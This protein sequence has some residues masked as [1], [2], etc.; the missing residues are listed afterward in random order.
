LVLHGTA[1]KTIPVRW[2]QDLAHRIPQATLRLARGGG[3]N[4]HLSRPAWFNQQLR[5]WLEH[6]LLTSAQ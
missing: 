5:D 6:H 3:H 1:D 2:G 4:I